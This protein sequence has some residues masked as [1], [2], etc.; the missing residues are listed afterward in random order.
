MTVTCRTLDNGIWRRDIDGYETFVVI[1]SG[2]HPC[3]YVVLSEGPIAEKIM[4]DGEYASN[5]IANVHGGW[6]FHSTPKRFSNLINGTPILTEKAA[7]VIGF[8]TA[9]FMDEPAP[10]NIQYLTEHELEAYNIIKQAHEQIERKMSK[11][12]GKDYLEYPPRV[13]TVDD[14]FDELKCVVDQINAYKSNPK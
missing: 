1:N 2:G 8:D 9:H 14:A 13:W 6:T 10:E 11:R 7:Y 5:D 4:I 3:G 12:F